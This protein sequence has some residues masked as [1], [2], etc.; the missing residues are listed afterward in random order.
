M[1]SP[2]AIRP[3][4]S[5]I[6]SGSS[7]DP[8]GRRG[9]PSLVAALAL[10]VLT[11]LAAAAQHA[12]HPSPPEAS[13]VETGNGAFAA[14]Q[15]V[16][17]RLRDEGDTDWSRVDLEALR[18]HLVDMERF[19]LE[20]VLLEQRA[21]EGGV[22]VVV[23]GTN[24]AASSSI[25]AAAL[26]HAPMLEAETG[27]SAHAEPADPGDHGEGA[28]VLEV[29]AGTPAEVE[30]IQGLGYVGLMATG[31]HHTEHHWLIATGRAPHGH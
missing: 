16:V 19:T 6:P 4:A 12:H 5:R 11:P 25:R 13:L 15:E 31:G 8:A 3:I 1:I 23:R 18:R 21:I 30:E 28:T 9:A 7:P 20:A 2:A 29:T 26:A 22:R 17:E 14:V 10:L 27:W 24:P